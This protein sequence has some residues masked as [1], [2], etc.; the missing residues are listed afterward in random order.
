EKAFD[1]PDNAERFAFFSRAV[2]ETLK[3][4]DYKPDLIHL[5]DWQTGL[6]PLYLKTIYKDDAFFKGIA[7][8]FTIHNIGYQGVFPLEDFQHTCLSNDIL[9]PDGLEYYGK[10][11]YLKGGLISAEMLT[12]V[13]PTYC[14]EIQGAEYGMGLEG[15]IQTRA[16]D[17]EGILN[18]ADYSAW[19]P[20]HD[21]LI[22]KKYSAKSLGGK[23]VCKKDLLS[24]FGF[25]AEKKVPV[26][27]MVTR[28]SEQKGIDI[29]LQALDEFLDKDFK[30]ILLG[31]GDEKYKG[32]FQSL[33]NL[34]PKKI[35]VKIDFDV[36]L[37]HKIEAGADV[38]VMPSKYEPCGLSQI[39]SL[40]YGTIPV[41]RAIGGLN[42][43]VDEVDE[44]GSVGTGF[45]FSE[46]SGDALK[47]A[48]CRALALYENKAVWKK[49]MIRAMEKD[50]SW[51]KSAQKYLNVYK[52]AVHKLYGFV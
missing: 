51:E 15:V 29:F 20:A 38:F 8:L 10:M 24:L 2:L 33:E 6:V 45:K 26:I 47:N 1:Y 32:L 5:N 23:W 31:M 37:A 40:K 41:V 46:Y 12:T 36:E 14:R 35:G 4:I 19:D 22:A 49:M 18:G 52:K 13:S 9:T 28:L 21:N 39:Y 48:I 44:T 7:T 25:K 30:L 16:E 42:D 3:E 34:H 27:G 43:T 17:I 50:F 11:S